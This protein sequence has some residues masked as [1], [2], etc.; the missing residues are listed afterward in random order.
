MSHRS[1]GIALILVVLGMI[2]CGRGSREPIGPSFQTNA[3][4]D[5]HPIECNGI[6]DPNPNAAGYY[7][8]ASITPASCLS[9]TGTGITDID[10][11]GMS[12]SCEG[13]LA[14]AFRPS[15]NLAP[16]SYDCDPTKEPYWAAKYFPAQGRVVRIAYLFGYHNDCGDTGLGSGLLAR[17]GSILSLVV[18]INNATVTYNNLVI[19][20]DDPGA[21]HAGDSE[22]VILDVRFDPDSQHWY[23]SQVK[24]SAHYGS[25]ADGSATLPTS[26]VQY[27]EK[28][29]GYP[30]V[31]VARNKHA[32][33]ASRESCNA[34]RGFGGLA[35]DNCDANLPDRERLSV[36]GLR[37]L[38][39][40]QR[41]FINCV[42]SSQPAFYPGT[43]CFWTPG[44]DFLGWARYPF[45]HPPTPYFSI[46]IA[47]FECFRYTGS[48][49]KACSDFGVVR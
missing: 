43:E 8:G 22:F 47:E 21:G 13:S 27:P 2:A 16:A 31:W 7:L 34:G 23:L 36:I 14:D 11:D 42:T 39:S 28:Y 12:D 44:D 24:Y 26:M 41:N 3:W 20:N 10:R 15:L 48:S 6:P 5:T 18:F 38:G 35:K 45:G 19:S 29:A 4:C 17:I 37:N 46:L 40:V 25:A 9:P 32:N 33:Y 49:T 1:V 30:R